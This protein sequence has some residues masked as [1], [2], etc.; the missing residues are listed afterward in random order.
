NLLYTGEDIQKVEPLTHKTYLPGGGT[1][2][3]DAVART[4]ITTGQR[5]EAMKEEERPA[6]VIVAI[7]TDGQ[8]NS[9]L[10]FGGPD[11]RTKVFGMIKK[12]TEQYNWVFVFIGA[13]QDAIQA[14]SGLGIGAANSIST[15]NN[16]KGV[17]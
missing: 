8:E 6:R 17:T 13:N 7:L 4:I 14:G 3:L 16:T 12:Q 10:E 9:S 11:G 1:A 15:A 2:L 5:L